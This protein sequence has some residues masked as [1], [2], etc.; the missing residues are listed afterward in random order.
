M[1]GCKQEWLLGTG[2]HE[3]SK[4][5]RCAYPL[6]SLGARLERR[7]VSILT[8]ST[9][10]LTRSGFLHDKVE[11]AWPRAHCHL[12]NNWFHRHIG[13]N[14]HQLHIQWWNFHDKLMIQH[15]M[16]KIFQHASALK[17]MKNISMTEVNLTMGY[18]IKFLENILFLKDTLQL[19]LCIT[20]TMFLCTCIRVQYIIWQG[21]WSIL[22]INMEINDFW[23]CDKRLLIL[24]HFVKFKLASNTLEHS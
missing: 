7:S 16:Q 23:F 1:F 4:K 13:N 3:V 11:Y 12:E 8:R 20:D 10:E 5:H 24:W 15:T 21:T 2:N 17:N 22:L 18:V 6:S 9:S 19:L 14:L